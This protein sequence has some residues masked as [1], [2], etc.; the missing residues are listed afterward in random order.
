M[1]ESIK[2]LTEI[3]K[4]NVVLSLSSVLAAIKK[5]F[6]EKFSELFGNGECDWNIM[7]PKYIANPYKHI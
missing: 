6:P 5:C 3:K 7:A 1:D 4:N 2:I